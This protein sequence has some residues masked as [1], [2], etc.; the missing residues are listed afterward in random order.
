VNDV[1]GERPQDRRLGLGATPNRRALFEAAAVAFGGPLLGAGPR[2]APLLRLVPEGDDLALVVLELAGGNDGLNTLVPLD[3]AR[4]P[5]LRPRLAAVRN[6]ADRLPGTAM[7]L[8]PSLG[9][10]GGGLL[11]LW[12][13]GL[14]AAVQ[15]VGYPRP[16]R[17][18]FKSRDVWHSADPDYDA[19]RSRATGWLGRAAD[20]LACATAPMPALGVGGLGMPLV[21]RGQRVVVPVLQR[22]EDWTLEGD[23]ERLAELATAGGD[24]ADEL[25][26]F[27]RSVAE[28]A[29]R[30]AERAQAALA[31]Y[32]PRADYPEGDLGRDLQLVARVLVSGFGT[33]LVHVTFGGFDTHAGQLPTHAAL[34]RQLGAALAALFADLEAHGRA[35]S[36]TVLVHS[37]FG[38]RAAENGSLGTDHGAAAPLFV[39][40]SGVRPGLHGEPPDLGALVD[41]DVP[42]TTDFRSVYA[43]LL[44]RLGVPVE[45]VLEASVPRLALF[46]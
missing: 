5:H 12:R 25:Q 27:V 40:G 26:A 17:S 38:R 43:A 13:R 29:V 44:G 21:L 14:V 9:E 37:E 4:F 31:S 30:G 7:A 35:A 19:T 1:A 33:R 32:R 45:A 42:A 41:G 39:L 22:L 15:G 11:D 36:T 3:D 2:A 28:A 16:D 34:L 18:H 20:V 24:P 6:G 10:G 8:H 46:A 23:A